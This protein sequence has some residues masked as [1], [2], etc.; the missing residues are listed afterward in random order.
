MAIVTEYYMTRTDGVILSRT[1]S[2]AGYMIERDG[3]HYAEAID[4][5]EFSRKYTETD[6]FIESEDMTEIKI[7]AR[8]Y[9]IITGVKE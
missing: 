3:I 7:K 9:D 1:Y 5:A 2:D 4:P 6:E 8:A